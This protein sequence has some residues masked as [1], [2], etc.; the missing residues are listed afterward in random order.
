VS[1]YS[2]TLTIIKFLFQNTPSCD[3]QMRIEIHKQDQNHRNWRQICVVHGSEYGWTLQNWSMSGFDHDTV[4][5]SPP[6][7]AA[8]R[9]S[10]RKSWA[11][12]IGAERNPLL[13]FRNQWGLSHAFI[14]LYNI[15][16]IIQL[17]TS[18]NYYSLACSPLLSA[19]VG[20][21]CG[22]K[23]LGDVDLASMGLWTPLPPKKFGIINGIM[24]PSPRLN[25]ISWH[26]F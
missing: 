7:G 2:D 15:Y 8:S 25:T 9:D 19:G 24:K 22:W 14:S 26:G 13:I 16:N 10:A 17:Q 6:W 1:F 21:Y 3:C 4:V 18:T 5:L 12:S 20:G 23:C 11:M